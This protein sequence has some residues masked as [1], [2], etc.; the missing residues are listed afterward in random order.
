[1]NVVFHCVFSS[2]LSFQCL[3][4]AVIESLPVL[5]A[6]SAAQD[7]KRV[8]EIAWSAVSV[9]NRTLCGDSS[10]Y[11]KKNAPLR[12]FASSV[13]KMSLFG[14]EAPTVATYHTCALQGPFCFVPWPGK[15][16][17]RYVVQAGTSNAAKSAVVTRGEISFCA[18]TPVIF[19]CVSSFLGSS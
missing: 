10:P 4:A 13:C 11:F 3:R 16:A 18:I 19:V 14:Y 12:R 2:V 6:A 5:E 1:M 7:D 15:G 8:V 9:P 17:E